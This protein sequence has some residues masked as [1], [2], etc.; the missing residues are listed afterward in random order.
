MKTMQGIASILVAGAIA[1]VVVALTVAAVIGGLTWYIEAHWGRE[2]VA[3]TWE[4]VGMIAKGGLVVFGV[5]AGWAMTYKSMKSGAQLAV[6]SQ[7]ETVDAMGAYSDYVNAAQ[8]PQ[9]AFAQATAHHAKADAQ[10]RVLDAREQAAIE[11][12]YQRQA[13]RAADAQMRPLLEAERLRLEAK[14][15]QEQSQR[16]QRRL[17]WVSSAGDDEDASPRFTLIQ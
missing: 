13:Q 6:A 3:S 9:K 5:S 10:I 11:A 4:T 8:G 7:H 17:P 14:Y 12:R 2:A 15:N 16:T 1:C